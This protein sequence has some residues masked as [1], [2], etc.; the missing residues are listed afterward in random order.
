MDIQIKDLE[1]QL[2]N[3]KKGKEKE[4]LTVR[5]N[6][7]ITMRDLN[8]NQKKVLYVDAGYSTGQISIVHGYCQVC[9]T[10]GH[11]LS[12]YM[13]EYGAW[14]CKTCINGIEAESSSEDD[15]T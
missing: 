11:V 2:I 3:T 10:K 6:G 1:K 13:G 9:D 14:I 4:K 7:L 12:I 5:L 15:D 8:N